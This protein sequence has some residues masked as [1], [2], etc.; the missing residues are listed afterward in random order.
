V[1]AESEREEVA[2]RPEASVV[3][4]H[5]GGDDGAAERLPTVD[6][7]SVNLRRESL[8]AVH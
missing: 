4:R 1:G 2:R 7:K 3:T 6:E 8:A 5:D